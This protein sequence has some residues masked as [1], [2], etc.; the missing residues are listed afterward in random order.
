M[1][2]PHFFAAEECN[3]VLGYLVKGGAFGCAIRNL[4]NTGAA[5]RSRLYWHTV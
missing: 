1:H 4:S 5:L 2:R 3:E